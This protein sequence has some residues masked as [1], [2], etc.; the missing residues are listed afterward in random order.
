MARQTQA[1]EF[2]SFVGGLITE[3]SPLTFP[4]N[5][6]L[7]I[8]NF[9]LSKDGSISRRLGM[10]YEENY[11]II[12]SGVTLS[13]GGVV[14]LSTSVW[15]NAGGDPKISVIVVQIGNVLN[16]FDANS[17]SVT[18]NLLHTHTFTSVDVTST[19]SAT[20]VDGIL[21]VAGSGKQPVA[22]TYEDGVI[23]SEKYTLKI[24]DLFGVE[25]IAYVEG[26]LLD[27]RAPENLNKRPDAAL[28]PDSHVYNLRNSTY[29]SLRLKPEVLVVED[30][31][32]SF[33][34]DDSQQG[35][36]A[37]AIATM[38]SNSDAVT[39]ALFADAEDGDDRLSERFHPSVLRRSPE[40]NTENPTGYFIIDALE[41]GTSRLKQVNEL[42][43]SQ[44]GEGKEYYYK[45]S[46]LPLDRTP[47]GA[48]AVGE[49]A[50][51]VWYAGF[52]GDV[53]GGDSYSPRMSSYVL[54]S[55][56]IASKSDLGVCHQTGDP[57]SKENSDL[58][59][60]DGGFIRVDEAYGIKKL[61]NIG[62]ALV[63]V[64]EN[65]I[66]AIEGGS[67]YG[68]TA[69]AYKV[70]KVSDHGCRSPNSVVLV[71]NSLLYWADDGIYQVGRSE[72]G[73]I[74]SSSLT[75]T[76]IQALYNKIPDTHKEIVQGKFDSYEKKVRWLYG[77]KVG[78]VVPTTELILDMNLG[79]FYLNE[80]PSHDVGT[81]NAVSYIE[82]PPFRVGEISAGVVHEG[83]P[84]V[85]EGEELSQVI[86]V[87]VDG[88]RELLYLTLLDVSPT[89]KYT[90]SKYKDRDFIDW[91]TFDGVGV[92]SPAYLITGYD[93]G[94]DFQ[95]N[96]QD[97]YIT[98]NFRK[99]EDGFYED[100]GG[101]IHPLHE[102][103]CKVTA[104]WEW[105]NSPT[106]GRWG[107]EFQAYRHKRAYIPADIND[108]YDNGFSVV[109][110][111][112][113]LRGKGRVLSLQIK[114]DP[115]KD[116]QLLGWSRIRSVAGNV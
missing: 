108:G 101:D 98:F 67:D 15:G 106:S 12:D 111:K 88:V 89:I 94:G 34:E 56:L 69:I 14:S 50:G 105:A 65:G 59:E 107:R 19:L 47:G 16:F 18:P 28:A 52:S 63:V 102:S 93:G 86:Q 36:G 31:I 114:T 87:P 96:K 68:F 70:S 97:P 17:T 58:L 74:T 100:E 22:F 8:K 44:A 3:A 110:T 115:L 6:A 92:D 27:L 10:D 57:T 62:S 37:A 39:S 2:N 81:P 72:L 24:R 73:D 4:G 104:Q 43:L 109:T 71:D 85:H 90:M 116:C 54:F 20:V 55:K 103:S 112:N 29:A 7:D 66:W 46:S 51:R 91:K 42:S 33:V 35:A 32:R 113:K 45:V 64:A 61:V 84:V 99:T 1:I 41:R 30:P 40:G 11:V 5:A 13:P 21:I 26:N 82:V 53:L 60:T 23:T 38:P 75:N 49:Y 76:T 25:T 78:Q 95:R 48:T 77:N 9:N 79:A 80:I 83:V